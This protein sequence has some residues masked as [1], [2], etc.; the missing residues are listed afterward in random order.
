[1]KQEI[2]LRKTDHYFINAMGLLQDNTVFHSI[3]KHLKGGQHLLVILHHEK[4]VLL[5]II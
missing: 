4:K 1:M 3:L 2:C 5:F